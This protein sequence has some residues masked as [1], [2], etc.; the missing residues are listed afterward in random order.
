VDDDAGPHSQ[1]LFTAL[2]ISKR[3]YLAT[4]G[5]RRRTSLIFIGIAGTVIVLDRTT[6]TEVW[7]SE[8]KGT[9]L[10]APANRRGTGNLG[11]SWLRTL[12]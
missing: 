1:I 8:L 5:E 3:R 11:S 10:P 4:S 12:C 2:A 6:G 7:R 9:F